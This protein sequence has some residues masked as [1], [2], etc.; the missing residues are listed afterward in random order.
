MLVC[1][2]VCVCVV[3]VAVVTFMV[4]MSLVGVFAREHGDR[5][6]NEYIRTTTTTTTTTVAVAVATTTTIT[7]NTTAATTTQ[8]LSLHSAVWSLE[9]QPTRT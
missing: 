6:R 1:V 8:P 4:V 3:M 7:I 9:P 2:C 5:I